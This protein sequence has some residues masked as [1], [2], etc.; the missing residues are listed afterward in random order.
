MKKLTALLLCLFALSSLAYSQVEPQPWYPNPERPVRQ[1]YTLNGL[2]LYC[3][4]GS[5]TTAAYYGVFGSTGITL[6]TVDGLYPGTTEFAFINTDANTIRTLIT[7]IRNLAKTGVKG[8]EGG[9]IVKLSTV[10]YGG[11]PTYNLTNIGMTSCKGQALEKTATVNTTTGI[12]QLFD[13]KNLDVNQIWHITKCL[14]NVTYASGT[15]QLFV[16]D[17]VS[18]TNTVIDQE[19]V[20]ASGKDG[21][22]DIC[23]IGTFTSKKNTDLLFEVYN[24]TIITAGYMTF[25]LYRENQ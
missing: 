22:A 11:N 15:P 17:G 2:T 12:S 18:S 24:S 9:W 7:T 8:A 4:G 19:T 23:D 1:A 20:V 14:I 3:V 5:T 6:R 13:K 21:R 10:S 16:Y 25:E